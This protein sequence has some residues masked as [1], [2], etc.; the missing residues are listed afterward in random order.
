[1]LLKLILIRKWPFLFLIHHMAIYHEG[2]VDG[3]ATL[4]G[5]TLDVLQ[6]VFLS[7]SYIL[8]IDNSSPIVCYIHFECKGEVHTFDWCIEPPLELNAEDCVDSRAI[9]MQRII[10]PVDVVSHLCS[11]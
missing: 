1:M 7:Q 2:G 9:C 5:W 11:F 8:H 3:Y 10:D 6:A 4:I